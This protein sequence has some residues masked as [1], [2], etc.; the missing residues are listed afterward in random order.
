MKNK[1]IKK[2][3]TFAMGIVLAGATVLTPTTKAM[4]N[5]RTDS[6]SGTINGLKCSGRLTINSREAIAETNY[7]GGGQIIARVTLHVDDEGKDKKLVAEDNKTGGTAYAVASI[8]SGIELTKNA[9]GYHKV[10]S[11]AYTWEKYTSVSY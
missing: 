9:S 3:T 7:Q 8:D 5:S 4:A 1:T 10:K 2:I 11:G 6:V